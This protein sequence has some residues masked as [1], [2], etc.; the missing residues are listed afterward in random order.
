M[1]QLYRFV[2]EDRNYRPL[3]LCNEMLSARA[4]FFGR[5]IYLSTA[6]HLRMRCATPSTFVKGVLTML[7][8]TTKSERESLALLSWCHG[9]SVG[10]N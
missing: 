9:I 5:T 3:R 1:L 10:D 7:S 4:I 8:Q 2:A 6:V